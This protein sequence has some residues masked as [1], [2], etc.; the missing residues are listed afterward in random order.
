MKGIN[1]LLENLEYKR[2]TDNKKKASIKNLE[3]KVGKDITDSFL[4]FVP[5]LSAMSNLS[6][7]PQY[8]NVKTRSYK[9]KNINN[10]LESRRNISN[11][12]LTNAH[13]SEYKIL[14]KKVMDNLPLLFPKGIP[15]MMKR[16]RLHAL[17][18]KTN[19][20]TIKEKIQILQIFPLLEKRFKG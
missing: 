12:C 6:P 9:M 15:L 8:M 18:L 5:P 11:L 20:F 16:K 2:K 3:I 13:D 17:F 1:K 19:K 10:F 7:P 14:V 4:Y